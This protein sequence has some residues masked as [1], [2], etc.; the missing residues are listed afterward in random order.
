MTESLP[1]TNKK[2]GL[3]AVLP[4][5]ADVLFVLWLFAEYALTHTLL[6][7]ICMALFALVTLAWMIVEKRVFFTSWMLF[8]GLLLVWCVIVALGWSLDRASSLG[9][10]RTLLI[11]LI[12]LSFVYQ[13]LLLQKNIERAFTLYM[14]AAALISVYFIVRCWPID[15]IYGRLGVMNVAGESIVVINP[16]W[17]GML[18]AFACA[19]AMQRW[20][21]GN[22]NWIF[23]I[24][25]FGAVVLLT[26]SAKAIGTVG[27]LILALALF[28]FPKKWGWKLLAIV[29]LGVLYFQFV[30]VN[31][32]FLDHIFFQRIRYIFEALAGGNVTSSVTERSSLFS[33]GANAFL[34]RPFAGWGAGCFR[35][36][37][38]APETYSH[39]NYI[40]LLV[41]GG[42]PMLALYYIPQ[43]GAVARA[44]RVK[45]PSRVLML[46]L[47]MALTQIVMDFGMVAYDDRTAL[48][49]LILLLATTRLAKNRPND[50]SALGAL[51]YLKNPCRVV[52]WC[53][54]RGKL[55][56]MPDK[57]Y[58]KLLYRGCLGKKL[59]LHPPVTMT[60]K[61][62]WMKLYDRDPRYPALVDK[63]AVRDYVAE[64]AGADVLVPLLGAWDTPDEIDYAA[65]PARFVL[66]CTHDSGSAVVCADP[67]SFDAAAANAFLRAR[68]KTNYY[69]AGREWPYKSVR[70]RVIAEAFIGEEDG[71]RPVDYK[72]FCFDGAARAAIVCLDRTEKGASYYF[73]DRDFQL[74]P[75]NDV[76][77]AAPAGFS[78][79]KPARFPAM[80]AL[81]ETLSAGLRQVRVDLYECDGKIYFG[82]MTLFDQS[83]FANDYVGEGDRIMGDFMRTEAAR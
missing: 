31:I 27:V 60:E 12:F 52:Q 69:W 64:R 29:V 24:A 74:L 63:L 46:A 50:G 15:V 43:I 55:K 34:E 57:L 14:I 68:L 49:A 32:Q 2:S 22:Y 17:I 23:L 53:S 30:L 39:N 77:A 66:K 18:A 9:M 13:Y 70:P 7:Q 81:A 40:E 33:I 3:A 79:P 44:F 8:Y 58:L 6:S 61:L 56:W 36:L 65:L 78:L 10:A 26:K 25:L 80:L 28:R 54:T 48:L 16:N 21:Y 71:A 45:R 62:Q 35:F 11:N 19:M 42:I 72:I 47:S 1:N 5:A 20:I 76:S 59:H 82:E 73:V 51:S 75:F 38:G 67:A 83:G 41:S 4:I 37:P